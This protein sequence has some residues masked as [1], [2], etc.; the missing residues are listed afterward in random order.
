MSMLDSFRQADQMQSFEQVAETMQAQPQAE[1]DRPADDPHVWLDRYAQ[2]SERPKFNPNI[3]GYISPYASGHWGASSDIMQKLSSQLELGPLQERL[4]PNKIFTSDI[5]ALRTL[6]A[7]QIKVIR[8]FERKLLESLNDKGKFG[9]NEDDIAAMQALT[10]ARS[11]ITAINKEQIGIKKNIAE[12]KIKQQQ[13]SGQGA[14][15]NQ[16][17]G[18]RP[19]T[20]F[21]MGR[22]IMD[23][24]FDM[25]PSQ[26][27][28]D[29]ATASVN[30]PT[31]NPDQA[32]VVLD[33]IIGEAQ[34]INPTVQYEKDNPTTYVLLG[35]TDSDY[36]F[37]TYSASGELLPDYPKPD[38]KIVDV[39][40]DG[41]NSSAT[42]DL[43]QV[44]KV[45]FKRDL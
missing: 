32:S 38:T 27:Q 18:G 2:F 14:N 13:Q 40:R 36:D 43:M 19:S 9:L 12:L 1:W 22:T 42:D 41:E 23:T 39:V 6:A 11:A 3:D 10:S 45:K 35:D 33:D 20:P 15:P 8:V 7:D 26:T 29:T 37:I 34:S 25:N 30:F 31:V 4:D 5:A 44:Y 21:E 16:V 28:V 24:I 17:S